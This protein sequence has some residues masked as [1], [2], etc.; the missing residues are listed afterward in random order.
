MAVGCRKNPYAAAGMRP[1]TIQPRICHLSRL[2][3]LAHD[4]RHVWI[5]RMYGA[6]QN[7]G[8]MMGTA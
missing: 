7:L 6:G 3:H 5:L 8:T 4:S 2:A 1:S